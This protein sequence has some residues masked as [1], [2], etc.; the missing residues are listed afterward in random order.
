MYY[1]KGVCLLE[2]AQFQ[3]AIENFDLAIKYKLNDAEA[4]FK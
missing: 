3:K 1:N 4:Y 2:L